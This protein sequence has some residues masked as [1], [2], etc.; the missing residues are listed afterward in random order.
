MGVG[1]YLFQ[2]PT[3]CFLGVFGCSFHKKVCFP[4]QPASA[5]SLVPSPLLPRSCDG[6]HAKPGPMFWKLA[7]M[8]VTIWMYLT[9]LANGTLKWKF[10]TLFFPTK[11]VL[12][13]SLSRLTI[14]QVS[15]EVSTPICSMGLEYLPTWMAWSLWFSCNQIF[16][17]CLW[18]PS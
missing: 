3:H 16:N 9:H 8:E 5:R 2:V 1:N 18:F 7:W 14:G 10:W 17:S 15:W 12:P 4:N 13:K 11:H 6:E